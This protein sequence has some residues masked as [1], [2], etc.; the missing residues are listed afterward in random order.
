M[1]ASILMG[2]IIISEKAKLRSKGSK[3]LGYHNGF[4][5]SK[6]TRSNLIP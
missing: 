1:K 4:S 5:P 3:N 2:A 6:G